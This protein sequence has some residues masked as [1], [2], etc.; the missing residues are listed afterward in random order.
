MVCCVI[1]HRAMPMIFVMRYVRK[2]YLSS[3]RSTC[4]LRREICAEGY[5][6]MSRSTRDLRRVICAEGYMSLSHST[7]GLRR[8]ICAEGIPVVTTENSSV[9]TIS[10][11]GTEIPVPRSSSFPPPL[12]DT[13]HLPW[14]ILHPEDRQQRSCRYA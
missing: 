5:L 7:R 8:E 12:P 6:S 4:G 14:K 13:G 2:G 3:S 11:R 1:F 9:I 10:C